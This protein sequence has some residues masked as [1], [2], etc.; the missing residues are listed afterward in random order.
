M[1]ITGTVPRMSAIRVNFDVFFMNSKILPS[2]DNYLRAFRKFVIAQ[3]SPFTLTDEDPHS[4][5]SAG[6]WL[7][8]RAECAEEV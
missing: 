8:P 2:F 7:S 1:D 5:F 3:L 6:D 4:T